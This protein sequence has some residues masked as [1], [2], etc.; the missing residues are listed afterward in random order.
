[1]SE[2][3]PTS[4]GET[5][6][7]R[8]TSL[9][10]FTATLVC[11]YFTYGWLWVGGDPLRDPDTMRQAGTF[12]ATLMAILGAHEMGHYIVA[13]RHGFRL[14]LP[15]F[16]PVPFFFGT[17]GAVI[18]LKSPPQSRTALLEMG[19]AGPLAGAAV[20]FLAL[21]FGLPDTGPPPEILLPEVVAE[22]GW[23]DAVFAWEPLAW[24][25]SLGSEP[26]PDGHAPVLIFNNPLVM[27]LLGSWILGA[28]PGRF[29]TLS[30]M[31]MAGWVGCFL[32][33]LNLV[34]IGQL[35]GGHVLGALVPDHARRISKVLLGLAVAGGILGWT[36][37]LVWAVLLWKTGADRNMEVPSEPPLTTRARVIA[38]LV[39][40][41]FVLTFMPLPI[42]PD[43]IAVTP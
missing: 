39:L 38:V 17:F 6:R 26:V 4:Q 27:D 2:V 16:I 19:A 11:V 1:M 23:L 37:W 20:A 41:L 35:D 15:Y 29:D 22:P 7:A 5:K 31:A 36:G 34:P 12:A 42:E 40:I 43:V 18:R 10:L 3:D 30:P 8:R 13:R 14:S 33:A 32:T 9:A 25:L 21:V 28:P 24:L